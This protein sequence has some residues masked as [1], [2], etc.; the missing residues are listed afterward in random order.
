[1]LSNATVVAV[2]S[3]G[4]GH[5]ALYFGLIP[6][7]AHLQMGRAWLVQLRLFSGCARAT[8]GPNPGLWRLSGPPGSFGTRPLLATASFCLSFKRGVQVQAGRTD[9]CTG[10]KVQGHRPL[11]MYTR[12]PGGWPAPPYG[13]RG[14]FTARY[15]VATTSS[16]RTIQAQAGRAGGAPGVPGQSV[17]PP[18]AADA[19]GRDP[20]R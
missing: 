20:G 8:S 2:S 14:T 6:T 19:S 4:I 10:P 15:L 5:S 11:P 18:A 17:G 13:T 3:A 16:K 12:A 9:A 7:E 1:M